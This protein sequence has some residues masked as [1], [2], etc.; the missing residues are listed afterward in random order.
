MKKLLILAVFVTLMLGALAAPA[1]ATPVTDLTALASYYGDQVP[2]Y[3]AFR[4]DDALF[5]ELDALK[6]RIAAGLPPGAIPDESVMDGLDATVQDMFGPRATFNTTIRS[7]L[8]D[9]GAVGVLSLDAA[10]DTDT[11]N[12]DDLPVLLVLSITDRD[13]AE[14]FVDDMID[15]SNARVRKTTSGDFT[16]YTQRG[17][18]GPTA[19]AISD[20]VMMIAS[21]GDALQLEAPESSLADNPDFTG[22]MTML[23]EDD[24]TLVTYLNIGDAL[25][26]NFQNMTA[27]MSASD[28]S[29]E[30]MDMLLPF[31]QN[32]P[33]QALG[34]TILDG[35]SLTFDFAQTPFDYS[36]LQ[37]IM[38]DIDF[39]SLMGSEPVDTS[40]AQYVPA[41]APFYIQGT[42]FGNYADYF[43]D[44]VGWGFEFGVQSYLDSNMSSSGGSGSTQAMLED[45]TAKDVRTF[46]DLMFAG[47]T[48]L[49][50][51]NDV[52]PSLN[53]NSAFYVRMLP[54]NT[55]W[56]TFEPA[57][58]FE[59]TDAAAMQHIYDSLLNALTQYEAN[60]SEENGVITLPQVIPDMIASTMGI[61]VQGDEFDV[62]IGMNSDV[63]AV[64]SRNAVEFSL[65]PDG[66]SLADDP[67]YQDAQ[68]Y[69]LPGAQSVFYIGIQ[70]FRDLLDQMSEA[71]PRSQQQEMAQA[72]MVLSLVSSASITATINGDMSSVGRFVL[73]LSE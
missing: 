37:G 17:S 5:D 13:G 1:A 53:G 45:V 28:P 24:Y 70:P 50:L 3:M 6:D 22:T 47:M 66:D 46:I 8:G 34:F 55:T 48:G 20:E 27:M 11:S 31:Y 61:K 38:G 29:R 62:L 40:F 71:M 42:N 51:E 9:T 64:G 41:D 4:T 15:R 59:V 2:V 16:V 68:A 26:Q 14:G 19:I 67:S 30:T 58:L 73:T 10:M 12:D 56:V 54:S 23:P 33:R 52:L 57:L 25:Y 72:G 7:W 39:S 49:N 18:S 65:N 21:N 69:F 43:I 60:F 36:A 63:F 32:Y 35:R 44:A